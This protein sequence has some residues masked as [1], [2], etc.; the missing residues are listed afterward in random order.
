M[1]NRVP[2]A[3]V[4]PTAHGDTLAGMW[5]GF[6][7]LQE[8]EGTTPP[9]LFAV[10]PYGSLQ[11]SVRLGAKDPLTIETG[12]TRAFSLNTHTGTPQAL[13]TLRASKGNAIK[14]DDDAMRVA[15]ERLGHMGFSSSLLLPWRSRPSH[16]SSSAETS[17]NMNRWSC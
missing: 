12:Q 3:V 15:Q 9:R 17:Q 10:E 1:Q 4:V 13:A 14:V 5:S 16:D 6:R 7:R 8:L 2:D 11:E